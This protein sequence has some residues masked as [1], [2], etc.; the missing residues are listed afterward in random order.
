MSL[1]ILEQLEKRTTPKKM[2]KVAIRLEK[3]Q[4]AIQSTDIVDKSDES[5]F[6]LRA[7]RKKVKKIPE[8]LSVAEKIPEGDSIA[9][10]SGPTAAAAVPTTASATAAPDT[11]AATSIPV[12]EKTQLEGDEESVIR[13]AKSAAQKIPTESQ[14]G[15]SPVTT[16]PEKTKQRIKLRTY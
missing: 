16:P 11:A 7:F 2:K 13:E 9:V 5:A 14:E 8:K 6:D 12:A 1:S 15:D 4:V 3:G 10:V